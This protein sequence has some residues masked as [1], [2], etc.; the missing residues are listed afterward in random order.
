MRLIRIVVRHVEIPFRVEFEHA[1]AKRA[2]SD[3]VI[4]EA[5][6]EDGTIGYGESV[7][8]EYVTGETVNSVLDSF[9]ERGRALLERFEGMPQEIIEELRALDAGEFSGNAAL[10]ALELSVLDAVGKATGAPVAAL[11]GHFLPSRKVRYS[12]VVG[13]GTLP[14]TFASLLKIRT[15]GFRH[16]KLKVGL[17][18]E[19]D[20]RRLKLA[21]F[22]LGRGTDMR[23]DANGAWTKEEAIRTI[24]ALARFR[25]SVVE[26]PLPAEALSET[27]EVKTRTGASIMLD[28]SLCSLADARR[29]IELCAC[30]MFNIRISKCGGLIKSQGIL[31]LARRNGLKCQLGCQVGESGLLS[32]AGRIFASVNPDIVYVEGSYD[33]FL[34]KRNLTRQDVSFDWGGIAKPI[35]GAGLGV[36]VDTEALNALTRRTVKVEL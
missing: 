10:C 19:T 26:Q 2:T 14:R 25:P 31:E 32:A 30:D 35:E 18:R 6:L 24:G 1:T 28:E 33:R 22:I 11:L 4:V 16:V 15:Y 23:V 34:L 20:I 3:N 12:A 21:R 17:G 29:A 5:H 13:A 9:L 8:R 7:P 36:D 27:A